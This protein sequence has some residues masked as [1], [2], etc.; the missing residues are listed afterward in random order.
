M[1][2]LRTTNRTAQR[3]AFTLIE[4][5]IATFILALGSLGLIVLFAGAASQQQRSAQLDQSIF[6]SKNAEA[7]MARRFGSIDIDN[8]TPAQDKPEQ[9]VWQR[10]EARLARPNSGIG[11]L[12]IDPDETGFIRFIVE[13]PNDV[14]LFQ[15]ENPLDFTSQTPVNLAPF[16]EFATTGHERVRPSSMR[17]LVTYARNPVPPGPPPP[18]P[19]EWRYVNDNSPTVELVGRYPRNL[20]DEIVIFGNDG[21]FDADPAEQSFFIFEQAMEGDSD[22]LP[23]GN[24]PE[25]RFTRPR[26]TDTY[27]FAKVD[28]ALGIVVDEIRL[29]GGFKYLSTDVISLADRVI[30]VQDDGFSSP[31]PGRPAAAYALLYRTTSGASSQLAVFTYSISGGRAGASYEVDET[32]DVQVNSPENVPIL[33]IEAE[34]FFDNTTSR[35]YI[36]PKFE[37]DNWIMEPG[38][39]LLVAG[40]QGQAGADFAVR[41]L[42]RRE[43]DDIPRGYIDRVPRAAGVSM[44]SSHVSTNS[45]DITVWGIQP[46]VDNI[47]NG[48]GAVR[49]RLKP[50]EVRIFQL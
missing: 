27:R 42:S 1:I 16:S 41:V 15:R 5:L 18:P 46:I 17:I 10:L 26:Q 4:V 40:E 19:E 38:Q 7:M 50:Q 22:Y 3:N 31:L 43:V 45:A 44:L 9:G 48:E 2:Q 20:N 12:S 34:L 11:M 24:N 23:S 28:P 36:Q 30:H 13:E 37:E 8:N 35:Y 21:T 6:I 25:D 33:Q 29:L 32:P 49:W 39:V 47:D 14:V